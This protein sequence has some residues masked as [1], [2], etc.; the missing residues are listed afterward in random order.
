MPTSASSLRRIYTLV[1]F[2][3]PSFV[4][5][6]RFVV[7]LP[8][9]LSPNRLDHESHELHQSEITGRIIGSRVPH[10]DAHFRLIIAPHL[11]P[12]SLLSSLIREIRQIRGPTSPRPFAEQTRPRITRITPIRDYWKDHRISRPP[13]RC[14]LPPHH[15]A[16]STPLFSSLFPHS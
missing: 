5:F 14:P 4:R 9:G 8:P 11:H 1:L 7:Q 15:C 12:C 2:S 3:L 16:A 10:A 6:V 13:R